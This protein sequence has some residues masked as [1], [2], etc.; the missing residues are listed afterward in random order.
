MLK[1]KMLLKYI[2]VNEL[3]FSSSWESGLIKIKAMSNFEK[4]M[5]IFWFLGPLIYLIE[6]DPADLRVSLISLIFL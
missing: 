1:R 4:I 2:S 3:N 5:T 6:R